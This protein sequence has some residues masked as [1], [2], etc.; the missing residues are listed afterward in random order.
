MGSSA[1]TT[2]VTTD[3]VCEKRFGPG[4]SCV[5]P[6]DD[7]RVAIAMEMV[8]AL[9]RAKTPQ[10]VL[11][12]YSAGISKLEEPRAYMSLSTRGL[13]PGHYRI[14]RLLTDGIDEIAHGN[15]WKDGDKLTVHQGGFIGELI[16]QAFPEILHNVYLE[17]DP[18]LGDRLR[19]Y[20]S[21]M[22]IP[23]FD[24]GEPLN[25]AVMLRREP[26]G[27]KEE[28][29]EDAILRANLVGSSVRNVLT[30]QQLREANEQVRREVEKIARIQRALLPARLPQIRGISLGA[31]MEMFDTAGGD[32]YDFTPLRRLEP[33]L[34]PDPDGPWWIYIADAAGHGPA[35]ATVVAMLNAILA[36]SPEEMTH[37][38]SDMLTFA[39][40]HLGAKRL[41]GTF[42]TA[43]LA[44]YEPTSREL[45]YARA[46]HNPAL[47]MER[48]P[49]EMQMRR[50]DAVG[51]VPL[52]VLDEVEYEETSITLEPGQTFVLYTDGITEAMAPDGRQFEV[53]GIERSL[54][55]CSGHPDCVIGH[56]TNALREHEAGRRPTDDQTLL[57]MRVD[58]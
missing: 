25:W 47:L 3:G 45:R 15:P 53:E 58:D 35:A 16:R 4:V 36:A 9:S 5:R 8:G 6:A 44:R 48:H 26:D 41:D 23:L 42:V 37:R 27:F 56:V 40:R 14:T 51:G 11:R 10:D 49:D 2:P 28:Q 21:I 17:N 30:A 46:G 13:P 39:N 1:E 55:E 29:L 52:G 32:L 24:D 43:I 7:S 19:E 18:V 34:E 38:P 31:S 50:L 57:V 54:T 20:G 33:S 22:A 12:E